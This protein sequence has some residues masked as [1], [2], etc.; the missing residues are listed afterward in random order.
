MSA[1]AGS[2]SSTPG[3]SR[4]GSAVTEL[5]RAGDHFEVRTSS[6]SDFAHQ[7]VVVTGPSASDYSWITIPG[8]TQ[9][10]ALLHERGVS[11]VPGIYVLGVV[12]ADAEY[13]AARIASQATARAAFAAS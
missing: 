8:V 2:S 3:R 12:G 10:G 11:P 4:P 5:A 9:D 7:V 1:A 13:V 6:R